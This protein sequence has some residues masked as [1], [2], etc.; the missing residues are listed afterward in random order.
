MNILLL[1]KD[2]KLLELISTKMQELGFLVNVAN[3]GEEALV[4]LKEQTPDIMLLDYFLKDINGKELIEALINQQVSCPQFIITSEHAEESIAVQMLNMG[5]MDY[6]V[7]DGIFIERLSNIVKRA[8]KEIKSNEKLKESE[9]KFRALFEQ[10][11]GYCMILDPNTKDGIPI[12]VDANKAAC[13]AHGYKRS[14][15]VGMSVA[16]LED[17]DAK[18]LV[19]EKTAEIM[20]GKPFYTE[21]IHVHKNGSLFAV[22]VNAQRIDIGDNPPLIFSTEYDISERK[23]AEIELIESKEKFRTQKEFLSMLINTIPNPVFYKD[24][25]GRY[26]GVNSAFTDFMGINAEDIIGKTVFDISPKTIAKEYANK[27]NELFNSKGNQNYESIINTKDGNTYNV[28]FDKASYADNSGSV[29]GLIGIITDITERKQAERKIRAAEENLQNT[30]DISPNI[31]AKVNIETG[32]FIEVNKAVTRILGYSII[33]FL[34]KPIIEFIHPDDN[35]KTKDEASEQKDGKV[36][37]SFENRYLCKD[38]SYKWLAWNSSVANEKGI[39]TAIGSD[40]SVRKHTELQLLESEEKYRTMIESSND[41]IWMLDNKGNFNFI[42]P[43][44]EIATGF[45]L[46]EVIGK[47]FKPMVLEEE[48]PFLN[49]VFTKT[50]LG[51]SVSYEMNL[52]TAKEN[53]LI[54]AVNTVPF[55]EMGEI[56]G[57]FSFARDITSK[58]ESERLLIE[59]EARF[60]AL[61]NASFGGIAIHDLGIIKDCNQGLSEIT[62]YSF[63]EL[64]GM[65]GLLCLAENSREIAMDNIT[66]SYEKAYEVVGLRKNGEEYPLRL[67]GKMIRNEGKDMRV[68]EFRDITEQKKSEN[69]VRRLSTAVQQNPSM[70]VITDTKG[71]VEYVN[72]KFEELTGYKSDEVIGEKSNILKSGKQGIE[73]YKEMWET[74]ISGKVWRGQFHNK[75]KNGELFW[76]AAS[77]SAVL[78]ED[79]E[80]INY[81]KNGEDI[82]QQK[83]TESELNI[84]LEKALE[85]DKLKSAFLTNMSH[86]IRTPMNGILGFINLLNEPNLSKSQIDQYSSII[87]Q[88]GKRLLN[89]INDIIDISRIEAGEMIISKTETSINNM[90]DELFS[91]YSMEA[92]QKGLTLSLDPNLSNKQISVNTDSQKLHSILTNFIKNAIKYT[93]KG[94]INFGYFVKQDMIVFFVRDTGIGIPKER[95]KAIFNRFEQADIEDVKVLEGSGLGLAISKAY[96]K[97][98]GGDIFVESTESVGSKFLLTIPY[99]NTLKIIENSPNLLSN[100]SSLLKELNLLIVEDDEVSSE[101]YEMLFLGIFKKIFFVKN[102]EEAVDICLNKP[103]IDIALMDVKMPIMDGYTATR[104]I[105]EFNKDIIIIA[106]TA[107]AMHGDKRKAIDAGCNDYITKPLC[108]RNILEKISDLVR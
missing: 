55:Y 99:T 4:F 93:E 54:L 25:K 82:T 97:M 79:G 12:I 14:E 102:G 77:I 83:Q 96:A 48:L 17:E 15:F 81:I 64:I 94:N 8:L 67:E 21:N 88:S 3:S 61:H 49:E 95:M 10:A 26:I 71:V 58:K 44:A 30:F 56:K 80:I 91:F 89:T 98:L 85:S 37:T 86:E 90:M 36:I 28:I 73:F 70:I 19:K 39:V 106:Q 35:Q 6:L 68:I 100:S 7:K 51:E 33:E 11:G 34:S 9:E 53:K 108:K 52:V 1:E 59:S 104:K 107:Y 29:I 32:Y 101:L 23:Q 75:K 2:S 65:D 57:M 40:I 18:S 42:N 92:D 45:V 50:M 24:I 22:A 84:A 27:D 47:S 105:R 76:E 78:N 38:G 62:G 60:K 31:I 87:N 63:D 20:I 66:N 41:I 69:E 5:A 16:D 74:I 72:P 43:Y 13:A 103:E 46:S